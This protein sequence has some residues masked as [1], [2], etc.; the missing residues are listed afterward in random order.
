[1]VTFGHIG[2]LVILGHFGH[3]GHLVIMGR[4]SSAFRNVAISQRFVCMTGL[5]VTLVN[6]VTGFYYGF[7]GH[8]G[9]SCDQRT[10]RRHERLWYRN[11]SLR[12]V[13]RSRRKTL[14]YRNV[15]ECWRDT[16]HADQVTKWPMWPMSRG[17]CELV[18]PSR[19]SERGGEW[20]CADCMRCNALKTKFL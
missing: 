2:H 18:C 14:Q 5:L 10:D 20:W 16:P 11:Y 3:F 13:A 9:H 7:I 1:M 17:L 4:I 15:S 6:L 12:K 8:I 19:T